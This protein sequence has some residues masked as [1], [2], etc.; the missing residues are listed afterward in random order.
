MS[1]DDILTL[2]EADKVTGEIYKI[3]N[4]INDMCYVGQAVSHRKN[5]D[6]Y[7][8][9]GHIGRFNDHISEAVN[10][11]KKKQCTYLNNAIRKYGSE[12]FTV[13]LLES[14]TKEDMDTREQFY[15]KEYDSL[16]PNGYNLT[17]GGKTKDHVDIENSEPL[18]EPKKRGR[19]FGYSHKVNTRVKMSDRMKEIKSTDEFRNKTKNVMK[20]FYDDKKVAK[21]SQCDLSGDV[22]KYILPVKKKNTEVVHD[23]II[24]VDGKKM[25]LASCDDTLEEKYE[26]FKQILIKAKAQSKNC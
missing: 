15:I 4:T 9:F 6:R 26:R 11:T 7:R 25:R 2:D 10:N 19:E 3:V 1:Q 13:T 22:E 5:K 17:K 8:P 18:N 12:N 23:Y 14:C 20:N 16:Y 21:L 24:K